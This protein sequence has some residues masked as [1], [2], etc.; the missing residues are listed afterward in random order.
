MKERADRDLLQLLITLL[1]AELLV[2]DAELLDDDEED[3]ADRSNCSLCITFVRY[4]S[5]G[6]LPTSAASE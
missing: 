1:V 2:A 3:G 6:V 5:A 4:S